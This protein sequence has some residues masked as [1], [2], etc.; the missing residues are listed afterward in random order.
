MEETRKKK[1]GLLKSLSLIK[2]LEIKEGNEQ[3]QRILFAII[4]IIIIVIIIV[5]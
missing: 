4:I 5:M 1:K 2:C 3:N